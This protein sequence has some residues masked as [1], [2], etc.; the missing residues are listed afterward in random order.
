LPPG[1]VEVTVGALPDG[2]PVIWEF[3]YGRLVC[4]G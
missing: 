2:A 4:G 3:G 1:L